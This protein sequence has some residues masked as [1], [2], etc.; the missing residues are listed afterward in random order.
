MRYHIQYI[1]QSVSVFDAPGYFI[2]HGHPSDLLHCIQ[3]MDELLLLVNELPL[4]RIIL[5]LQLLPILTNNP[6]V[7]PQPFQLLRQVLLLHLVR[8]QLLLNV[9]Q[10]LV[11]LEH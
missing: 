11:V 2:E 1:D 5:V 7:L 8:H 4:D 10:L 9:R 6:Q 3:E